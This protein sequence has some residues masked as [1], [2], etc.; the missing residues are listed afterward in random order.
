ML[1][2]T[3]ASILMQ[4]VGIIFQVYLSNRLGPEGMGLFQLIASVYFLAIIY[5]TSSIR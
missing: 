1:L 5:S 3:G 4:T 2:M